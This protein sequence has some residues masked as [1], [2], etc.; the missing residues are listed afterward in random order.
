MILQ[1]HGK[2]TGRVSVTVCVRVEKL[3]IVDGRSL[4]R[5]KI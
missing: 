3:T 5:M 4:G 2:L 1:I